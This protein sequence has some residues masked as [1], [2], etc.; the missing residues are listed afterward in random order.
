KPR[1]TRIALARP[2]PAQL[3]IYPARFMTLRADDVETAAVGHAVAQF[4]I[5]AAPG[6]VRGNRDRPRVTGARD[7]LRFLHVEFRV[8]DVMRNST[9]RKR[10]SSRAPVTDR[11]STRLNSSHVATSYAVFCLKKKKK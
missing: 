2:T 9:C 11:K 6:H 5:G 3:S 10:R 4:N 7:D 8:Q 1:T